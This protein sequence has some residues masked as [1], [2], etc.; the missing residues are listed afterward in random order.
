VNVSQQNRP[1]A[2]RRRAFRPYDVRRAPRSRAKLRGGAR[3]EELSYARQ[4]LAVL[5]RSGS[6]GTAGD[7]AVTDVRILSRAGGRKGRVVYLQ[8]RFIGLPVYDGRCSVI[9]SGR[10]IEVTGRWRPVLSLTKLLPDTTADS[11]VRW[12]FEHVFGGTCPT[13]EPLCR[14]ASP[15]KFEAF[16]VDGLSFASAHVTVF[17]GRR[18]RLAWIVDLAQVGGP[19]FEVALD[20]RTLDLLLRRELSQSASA[21]L[22][23]GP[24][25]P[26]A[27]LFLEPTWATSGA[28]K[29]EF[30]NQ[31]WKPPAAVSGIV[32]GTAT[33]DLHGLNAFTLANRALDLLA[34]FMPPPGP[35][36]APVHLFTEAVSQESDA[37]L[38][39]ERGVVL[40]GV[41]GQPDRFAVLDPS[42]VIHELSHLVLNAAVGGSTLQHPFES[43]GESGAVSE[44]L[45]DFLGLTIWNSIRRSLVPERPEEEV[46]GSFF[47]AKGRDYSAYFAG[48][49]P[50]RQGDPEP[51]VAGMALCG[52]LLQARANLID[53]D[54]LGDEGADEALWSALGRGLSSLPHD[55]GLPNFC[56]VRRVVLD[57]VPAPLR[58]TVEEA[59]ED[60]LKIPTPC[61]HI[62]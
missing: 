36:H 13:L 37:A 49:G 17:A 23:L 41:V 29:V 51:H 59:F 28:V 58:P 57:N 12:A 32:C 54:A 4:A 22:T 24:G 15:E 33:R 50:V 16:H 56:C 40:K 48:D 43:D 31:A 47:L 18:A 10:L 39:D 42:V 21:C 20:A 9:F 5:A 2:A 34:R 26:S 46:F 27:R 14:F 1:L 61:P 35:P 8:Q 11:A 30:K 7:Y 62:A 53:D 38:A 25:E 19:R 45:A 52:A 3:A 55:E 60:I 44:G 6:H